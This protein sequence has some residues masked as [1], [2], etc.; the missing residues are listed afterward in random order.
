MTAIEIFVKWQGKEEA[1]K[2]HGEH[3]R[4]GRVKLL[5]GLIVT[6]FSLTPLAAAVL[7][8]LTSAPA[9]AQTQHDANSRPSTIGTTAKRT[10]SAQPTK[11]NANE[12]PSS[13]KK[14]Q[15]ACRS[16]YKSYDAKSDSYLYR[17]KK[18]RCRL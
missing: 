7:I 18:V 1:S 9:A 15:M 13:S 11:A 12:A 8:G 3:G 17:G 14:H 2:G 6:A 16:K 4:R 10:T 5:K